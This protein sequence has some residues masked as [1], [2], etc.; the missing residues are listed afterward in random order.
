MA[1]G[2]MELKHKQLS[3]EI[4]ATLVVGFGLLFFVRITL[5]F[6]G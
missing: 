6:F 4:F 5:Y 2:G 1:D 3:P